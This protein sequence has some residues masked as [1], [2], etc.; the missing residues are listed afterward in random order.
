MGKPY[1]RLEHEDRSQIC[2]YGV[3][4]IVQIPV[5]IQ[6]LPQSILI[7]RFIYFEGVREYGKKGTQNN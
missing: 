3:S 6:H 2:E 4:S 1:L 7:A 5:Q